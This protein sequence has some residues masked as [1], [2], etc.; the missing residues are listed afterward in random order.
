MAHILV[1]DS[2][3]KCLRACAGDLDRDGH[4]V[5]TASNGAEALRSV[6][7]RRP[8]V[9]V[10]EVDMPGMDG[11][12]LMTRVLASDRYIRVVL[13]CRSAY[14]KDSFLSWAADAYVVKSPDNH[15]LRTKLAELLPPVAHLERR[16]S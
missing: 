15:E 10:T 13:N 7:R 14:H 12:D 1:V 16:A 3:T 11:I 2:D 6:A 9:V 5:R 8:D 4:V